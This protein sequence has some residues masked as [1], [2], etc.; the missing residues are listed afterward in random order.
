MSIRVGVIST[1]QSLLSYCR[2][3]LEDSLSGS[4][5]LLK[6]IDPT[7]A[8]L[9][10]CDL[11][12]WDFL[13]EQSELLGT[14][15]G[16][17]RRCYFVVQ[18]QDVETVRRIV[19]PSDAHVLLKPVT[20]AALS[21][22]LAETCRLYRSDAVP[23]GTLRAERDE[24]LQ[25]LMQAN[26]K[27]QEYDQART[28]FLA[29]SLHDFRAPL[30]T[31]VGYC[32]LLLEGRTENLIAEQREILESMHRS[33]KR[34][35]RMAEAMFQL[36]I[37]QKIDQSPCLQ[38]GDIQECLNQAFREVSTFVDEKRITL[39]VNLEASPEPLLFE[40]GRIDQLF[41]NLL[42]NACK[43]TPRGGVIEIK[44]YPYFWERRTR[45]ALIAEPS[46]NRRI[47]RINAPNS[48][49][50]DFRDSGPGIA[51]GRLD[52][53][54]EEYISYSGSQDRSGGGL[55]LAICKMIAL[56]HQG[57][58]WAEN[59]ASGAVFSLVLPFRLQSRKTAQTDN[60][61]KILYAGIA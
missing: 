35:T 59:A 3:I 20:R 10:E 38:P 55:G 9:S 6:N 51:A 42:D 12:I 58:I 1:D 41:I 26:L 21:A 45:Q 61:S 19:G 50:I 2:E 54:F 44:G 49:R 13:P 48:F 22:F 11:C 5:W 33:A 7:A 16:A 24:V 47:L 18:F 17:L 43:F 15:N 4:E 40:S 52:E 31:L 57:A 25:C 8:C 53:I 28:N 60:Y 29:R 32:A 14:V 34:L 37:G 36:S 56:Q 30:T 39:T 23:G 46:S 27:L